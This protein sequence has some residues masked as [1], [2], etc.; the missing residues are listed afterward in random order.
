MYYGIR[1][2]IISLNHCNGDIHC[3]S[4]SLPHLESTDELLAVEARLLLLSLGGAGLRLLETPV[5]PGQFQ[6]ENIKGNVRK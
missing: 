5:T 1:K 4:L 2:H 6:P 3:L